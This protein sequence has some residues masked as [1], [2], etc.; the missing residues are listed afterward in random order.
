MKSQKT[1]INRALTYE[2]ELANSVTHGISAVCVLVFMPIIAVF[3]QKTGS[4]FKDIIGVM[5]FLFSIFLMFLMSTIYHAAKPETA[6]KVLWRKMDH[7]FIF[8]AIAGSST[9]L[10]LSFIWN[11]PVYGK[12]LC[13]T[14]LCAQ[15]LMVIAGA[16]FKALSKRTKLTVTL[17]IYMA[18]GWMLVFIFPLFIRYDRFPLF[19]SILVGGLFYTLGVIA[20][21]FKHIKYSH[22]LWHFFVTFGALA[23]IVGICFFLI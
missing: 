10:A 22:T 2:E 20:F 6:Q 13:V 16:L 11:I 17:P 4:D 12:P 1:K 7:I 9:P 19:F 23:H 18:M 5:V 14:L 3:M 8:V 21:A 15:W